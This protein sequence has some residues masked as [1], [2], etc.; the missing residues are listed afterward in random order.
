[1]RREPVVVSAVVLTAWSLAVAW[2]APAAPAGQTGAAPADPR[3]IEFFEKRV[4][5]VLVEQ[6]VT[7]HG[8]K[9]VKG[10]L[11]L[12]SRALLMKGG[13]S[14][15]AI[16]PGNA[17]GSRLVQAIRYNQDHLKM[18]PQGKLKPQQIEDLE[19]WVKTGAVWPEIGTA[20]ANS[21]SGAPKPGPNNAPHWAFLPVRSPAVPRVKHTSWVK[22]PI[23]AFVLARLEAKGLKPAPPADRRTLLRRATFDLI[24][25]PPTPEEMDAF[26]RDTS[27][28]AFSRVV[29]RLLESPAYGERWGR[30]W[31]DVSRYADSN[32]LDENT[33]FANAFRYRDWVVRSLNE[34]KPYD[35]FIREQVAGDLLP[36]PAEDRAYWDRLT[37]TGFL[38]LGP[39]VLA[40][41]DKQKMMMDIV[42]EQ[43]DVTSKA[44]L[45]LTL[46]CARCHD[47]KFDP[48]SQKEYYA[49]AG[50]FKS[51]RT[52]QSLATV[53][54]AYERPAATAEAMSVRQE[55]DRKLNELREQVKKAVGKEKQQLQQRMKEMDQKVPD[56]P[57]VLA[58]E[59]AK[60]IGDVK[61]HIRGNHL[62]LGD[63]APRVFPKVLGA[64]HQPIGPDRSGRLELANWL[65]QPTNPL[66]GR[67]M[68][69]RIWQHHFGQGIVRSPD[70]FGRLGEKPTHPELL[71]W[72]A[73]RFVAPADLSA[74]GCGWSLKKLH[75]MMMLTNT[76]QMSSAYD[77][78][79]ALADPDN[80]LYWRANRRRLEIEAIRD[81]MLSVAGAL[82]PKM[83]GS[84]LDTPNFGYVTNDQSRNQAQ[85][86]VPRRSIY[87]PVIRNAVFDVFQVYDF[88]E[89]SFGNGKR[90][91]TTVAP[92]ALFMLNG[93][94]VQD[95]AAAFAKRVLA[96]SA[97]D[98]ERVDHAYLRA[99]GR[100]AAPD[101]IRSAVEYIGTVKARH[102]ASESD[103]AKLEL[104]AWRNFCQVLFAS[105][106]FIYVH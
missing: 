81:G 104:R 83:G 11:R 88:V 42:D 79:S 80:S 47:H 50:I 101:E 103:A 70:N 17:D 44:F 69:N 97:A 76:Y 34:D 36:R 68:V 13:E 48:L 87:L 51:T 60:E 67:V 33:A 8:S 19:T 105:N 91:V 23:D 62:T 24:G 27:P 12:D 53:A 64:S 84:L 26:L 10:G 15:A 92:Q 96:S 82:D 1:M 90:A 66:T 4:R 61:V 52:M 18:P 106:E 5:P 72:L 43:I 71:D 6:C 55:Y 45:G 49:F 63:V 46:S 85:Y 32:G 99:F 22:S 7:C 57:M 86:D 29:D 78:G 58:V 56:V 35:Q 73:T 95:Q 98:A 14:G 54:R 93:N 25:L 41:P 75:R 74:G 100:S 28:Q 89:P 38:V 3:A 20:A 2:S 31:L 65:A 16:V 40:E 37:A 102:S 21:A 30:H 39:K 59:E 94:F 9:L 77:A